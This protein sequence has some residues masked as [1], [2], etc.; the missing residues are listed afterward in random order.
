MVSIILSDDDDIAAFACADI[1][2]AHVSRSTSERKQPNSPL[3]AK[4]HTIVSTHDV[5]QS[6]FPPSVSRRHH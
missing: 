4:G 5:R 6:G 3:Q 1:A 2:N